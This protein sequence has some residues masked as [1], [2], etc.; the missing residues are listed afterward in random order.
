MSNILGPI[1]EPFYRKFHEWMRQ[2]PANE[3]VRCLDLG[4][5]PYFFPG[6]IVSDELTQFGHRR[7]VSLNFPPQCTGRYWVLKLS[8]TR[9]YRSAKAYSQAL[10]TG[11]DLVPVD[12]TL[13][14]PSNANFVIQDINL[15]LDQYRDECHILQAAFISRGVWAFRLYLDEVLAHTAELTG[16]KFP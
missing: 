7:M 9:V 8:H 12:S 3:R 15:G 16:T 10:F 2:Q 1:V 14:Y 11:V 4:C 6:G 5:V 13:S